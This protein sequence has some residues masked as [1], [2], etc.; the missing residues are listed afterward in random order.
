MHAPELEDRRIFGGRSGKIINIKLVLNNDNYG[1]QYL[2]LSTSHNRKFNSNLWEIL[3]YCKAII[4]IFLKCHSY[5]YTIIANCC[6]AKHQMKQLIAHK[7]YCE[8]KH[9]KVLQTHDFLSPTHFMFSG[10]SNTIGS[11]S[12]GKQQ[13]HTS[14]KNVNLHTNTKNTK[15]S[16]STKN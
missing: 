11:I 7:V 3:T 4:G 12:Q 5:C 9:T 14:N 15:Y 6:Y 8:E 16:L 1:T 2:S 13:L 10:V